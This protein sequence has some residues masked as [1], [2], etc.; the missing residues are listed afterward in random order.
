MPISM[1][2]GFSSSSRSVSSNTP[3]AD[4]TP[5]VSPT[6]A[7]CCSVITLLMMSAAPFCA[8]VKSA[9]PTWRI[10]AADVRRL[11]VTSPSVS[12]VPTPTATAK[13]VSSERT[14]LAHT[15]W[16]ASR[17]QRIDR[18]PLVRAAPSGAHEC[19]EN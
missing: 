17:S 5:G 4:S 6:P 19:L 9:L 3:M 16:N 15:L 11:S 1:N 8:T 10:A 2:S 12:T 14:R 13:A 7:T 18:L